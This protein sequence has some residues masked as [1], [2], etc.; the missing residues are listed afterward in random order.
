MSKYRLGADLESGLLRTEGKLWGNAA[1]NSLTGS[2]GND[3]LNGEGGNDNMFGGLGDDTYYANATYDTV[4][5][6]SARGGGVDTVVSSARS[7]T[8]RNY[9]EHLTLAGAAYEGMGNGLD[10]VLRGT[11]GANSRPVTAAPTR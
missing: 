3:T 5:E 4:F 2:S 11:S 9:V 7:Y 8:L 6:S 1:N 10:N